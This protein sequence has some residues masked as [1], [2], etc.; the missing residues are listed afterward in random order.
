M[1]TYDGLWRGIL[2]AP[3]DGNQQG[4][5]TLQKVDVAQLIEPVT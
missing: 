1:V 2:K 5:M 3:R 4:F